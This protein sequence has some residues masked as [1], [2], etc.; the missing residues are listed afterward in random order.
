MNLI[1]FVRYYEV[2][3]PDHLDQERTCSLW[4]SLLQILEESVGP[5]VGFAWE[6]GAIQ[7]K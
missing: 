7:S 4:W 2:L 1:I 6:G 5:G 3:T